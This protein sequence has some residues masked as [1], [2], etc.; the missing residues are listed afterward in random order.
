MTR[1]KCLF[2]G[3]KASL[4]CDS[5]IG[6]ER[7]RGEMRKDGYDGF[8]AGPGYSVPLKY[9][10]NHTC[11]APLC[12]ACAVPAGIMFVRMKHTSFAETT[13]YCPGHDFGDMRTEITGLQAEAFRS[14]WRAAARRAIDE[15]KPE[16][17][18]LGMFTG[19]LP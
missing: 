12:D 2:C 3:G 18:Q 6:W 8:V 11:D 7:K 17:K 9:R 10:V 14:K 5:H 15:A 16:H 4:L 1:A 13:D 19:L